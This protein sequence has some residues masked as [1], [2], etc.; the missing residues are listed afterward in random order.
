MAD[1]VERW[2]A[3]RAALAELA[4]DPRELARRVDLLE[5]EVAEIAGARLRP[6]EA[7]EIRT[8]LAAAQH[9]EAIA[10]GAATVR[11][12]LAAEGAGAREATALA[13][14]EARATRPPRPAVRGVR[15]PADR[16]RGR[17]R[18][19]RRRDPRPG[20]RRRSRSR[21]ARHPRGAARARSSRSNAATA[22]ARPR[23]SPTASGHRPSSTACGTSTRNGR[24]GSARRLPCWPRSRPRRPSCRTPD[25]PRPPD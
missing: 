4:I 19:C 1:V 23:S 21:R 11:E 10:R 9:G 12:A 8:R 7:E 5:H 6:G 24:A 2:R 14:R 20:R 25:A 18:R 22:T 13:A 17:A 3:N 16:P 15:G